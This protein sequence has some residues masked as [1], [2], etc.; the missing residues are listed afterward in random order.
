MSTKRTR[1]LIPVDRS[2][3]GEA[4]LAS[5]FPLLLTVEA[6]LLFL[7]VQDPN[8]ATH[9]V[10]DCAK[11]LAVVM[12]TR[13]IPA[14]A[15]FRYGNPSGEILAFARDMEVDL[16]AMATHGRSGLRRMIMG[17]VTEEVLRHAEVP[18][19]VCHPGSPS[20]AWDRHLA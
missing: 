12:R 8:D 17:S 3:D 7:H 14:E 6:K 10:R 9:P 4:V 19:L 20:A 13:C 16:I 11:D 18:L 1:I 15:Y 2:Q 5:V